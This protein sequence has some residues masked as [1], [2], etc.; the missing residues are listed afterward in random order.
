M[1]SQVTS[2][3]RRRGLDA[4]QD[5]PPTRPSI[6]GEPGGHGHALVSTA[7]NV[8]AA[9]APAPATSRARR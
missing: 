6:A 2:P 8:E 9:A 1:S 3:A 7:A 4:R 5:T